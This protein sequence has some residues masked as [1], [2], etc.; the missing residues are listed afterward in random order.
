MDEKDLYPPLVEK[1]NKDFSLEA[2]SLPALDN[3]LLIRDYLIR[4]VTELL[5]KDRDRFLHNLYQID[6]NENKVGEIFRSKDKTAIPEKL[7][8]LIIERQ[9]LRIK[10]QMLYREGKL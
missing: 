2:K 8:D 10:T 3:M 4:K 1:I 9:L 5:S 7:A 6:V